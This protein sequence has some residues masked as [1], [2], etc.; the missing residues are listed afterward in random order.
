MKDGIVYECKLSSNLI[1]KEKD[2]FVKVFN[3]VFN[4]DYNRDWFNWKYMDNIYGD[5]YIVLAYDGD[6]V[7][8]I[9]SFGEMTWM[10]SYP[11]NLVILLLL[12]NIEVE[13]YFQ[14]EFNCFGKTKE[15]FIYNFPNENSLPLF[16]A[17]LEDK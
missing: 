15:A 12:K 11:I 8:G 5:S 13:V 10:V 7:V 14:N 3:E 17:R 6:K 1:D 16:K 4:L 2:S 9:R